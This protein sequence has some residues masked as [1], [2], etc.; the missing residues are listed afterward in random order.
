MDVMRLR[1]VVWVGVG[2]GAL[3]AVGSLARWER[4]QTRRY[5]VGEKDERPAG[6]HS[7]DVV[8]VESEGVDAEGNMVVDDFVAAVDGDGTVVATDE[9]IA[10]MTAE[11]DVLVDETLSIVGDDGE[12]HAV[13]N[14]R[15]F[16]ESGNE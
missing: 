8:E 6:E 1:S 9:T 16:I 3:I 5:A 2:A 11:G 7:M 12:L 15:A 4:V 13:E 14:N 10:V